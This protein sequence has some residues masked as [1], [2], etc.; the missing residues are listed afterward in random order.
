MPS[1][2]YVQ[3][4]T[5]SRA[6]IQWLEYQIELARRNGEPLRIQHAA[7]GSEARIIGTKYKVDG[8]CNNTIYEYHG[9]KL[10]IYLTFVLNV[11]TYDRSRIIKYSDF[12]LLCVVVYFTGCI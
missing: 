5:Y 11:S 1:A 2:G 10:F 6:S 8:R 9:E 7:N 12:I 3:K 4:D